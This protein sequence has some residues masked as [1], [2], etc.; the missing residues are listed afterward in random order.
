MPK[1]Q[2]LSTQNNPDTNASRVNTCH[3]KAEIPVSLKSL[4]TNRIRVKLRG[5]GGN[6]GGRAL[7][8]K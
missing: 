1:N 7:E 8:Q 4:S 3:K 5:V 2:E 6:A